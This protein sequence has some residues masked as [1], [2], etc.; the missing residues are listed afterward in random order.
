MARA[1]SEVPRIGAV[2]DMHGESLSAIELPDT[3]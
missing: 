2:E 1:G 3:D